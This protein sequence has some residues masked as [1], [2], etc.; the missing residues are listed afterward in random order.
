MGAGQRSLPY[1]GIISRGLYKLVTV[2]FNI[3]TAKCIQTWGIF[4]GSKSFLN[5]YINKKPF[6][7]SQVVIFEKSRVAQAYIQGH[8]HLSNEPTLLCRLIWSQNRKL[9]LV[10]ELN[11]HP[12]PGGHNHVINLFLKCLYQ[13]E[14]DFRL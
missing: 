5:T 1:E 9:R 3:S 10:R 13:Q 11:G 6:F 12:F 7:V 2:F 8:F 4:C 14:A